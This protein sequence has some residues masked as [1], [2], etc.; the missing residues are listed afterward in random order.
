MRLVDSCRYRD[1]LTRGYSYIPPGL[2]PLKLAGR[3]KIMF[4]VI[5]LPAEI[6][7]EKIAQEV[8]WIFI[9]LFWQATCPVP[10][11]VRSASGV[12]SFLLYRD[13]VATLRVVGIPVEKK[14][15]RPEAQQYPRDHE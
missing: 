8:S 7:P 6:L 3:L 12:T 13:W 9:D 14:E 4:P 15:K 2:N 1:V 10:S 5:V 11:L